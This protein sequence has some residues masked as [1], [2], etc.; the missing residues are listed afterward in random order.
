MTFFNILEQLLPH[1]NSYYTMFRLV[2]QKTSEIVC[3][4][5]LEQLTPYAL[6][7]RLFLSVISSGKLIALNKTHHVGVTPS[8]HFKTES[9]EAIRLMCL[10]QGNNVLMQPRF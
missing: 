5:F 1:A 7:L 9:I 3:I 6:I 8:T 10:A 4:T 2:N